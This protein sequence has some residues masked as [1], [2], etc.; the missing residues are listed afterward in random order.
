MITATKIPA[1]V[2]SVRQTFGVTTVTTSVRFQIVLAILNVQNLEDQNATLALLEDGE[3]PATKFVRQ[4]VVL[5]AN[6]CQAN[7]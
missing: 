5:A 4:T 3:T 6:F 1:R 2:A 7:V